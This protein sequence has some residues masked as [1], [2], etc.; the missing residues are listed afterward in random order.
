MRRE[1]LADWLSEDHDVDGE[2]TEIRC[3][4]SLDDPV[5]SR[6]IWEA[7]AVGPE[8]EETVLRTVAA[9]LLMS[10]SGAERSATPARGGL[11]HYKLRRVVERIEDDPAL[12]VSVQELART[13]LMSPFHFAHQFQR[14]TGRSPHRFAVERR[15][16]RAADLLSDPTLPVN[17][18]A[19]RCGFSHGSHMSRQFQRVVGRSPA[20]IRRILL[21]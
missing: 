5:I 9:R 14:T 16:S 10:F 3:G 19:A 17:D 4:H 8:N 1:E 2:Y 21:L 6:L 15:L 20:E 12:A 11:P 18:I 7:M 13:V